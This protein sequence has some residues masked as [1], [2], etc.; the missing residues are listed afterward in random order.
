M[1]LHNKSSYLRYHCYLMTKKAFHCITLTKKFSFLVI[2]H[3]RPKIG[4]IETFLKGRE[5]IVAN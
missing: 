4:F 5:F 1:S 3:Y 2:I